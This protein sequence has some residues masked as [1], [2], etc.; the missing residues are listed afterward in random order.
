MKRTYLLAASLM[1]MLFSA[2]ETTETVYDP[3]DGPVVPEF[4]APTAQEFGDLQ[5]QA[6]ANI[7]QEFTFINDPSGMM[8]F[9]SESGVEITIYGGCLTVNGVPV[10]GEVMLEYVEIF[11]SGSMVVTGM[12]TMGMMPDGDLAML[13]SGGEFYVNAT[14]NGQPVDLACGF[15]LQIP[16]SLTGGTDGDMT[17]W[18]G[19]VAEDGNV[20]WEEEDN[21]G[22]N[23]ENGVF[24][25][26]GTYYAFVG[27]FGW[28][29][30]DRFYSDPR[31][32]TTIKV[33]VPDGF[34]NQNSAVYISY[35]E[36]GNALGTLDVYDPATGYFSEH[37]GQIPIG[38]ECHVIFVSE[39][40]GEW[41]YA[42]KAVTITENGVITFTDADLD[43]VTEAELIALIN[44]LP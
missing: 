2:C 20:V 1:M 4:P 28:T 29:N 36:E 33:D 43:S 8:Q 32:K 7:T 40:N 38:L 10:T 15:Q 23:Q 37:Y 6:L 25:E 31:P 12:P 39:N 42:I 18:N 44:A 14:H 16:G 22:P 9:M 17:L 21:D 27:N 34:T 5:E 13:V 30:V 11:N 19:L 41:I 24:V 3:Q 26:G 35:N